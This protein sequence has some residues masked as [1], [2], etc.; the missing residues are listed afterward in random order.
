MTPEFNSLLQLDDVP[1]KYD[2]ASKKTYEAII[3]FH[4]AWR[5]RDIDKIVSTY[6]ADVEYNDFFQ[7][8][9]IP[10]DELREY[11]QA[12]MPAS[13]DEIQFYIDRLR[14][15][16]DTAFLQYKI[17]LRGANGL[18]SFSACEAITV[19]EGLIVKV[20]DYTTLTGLQREL[21]STPDSRT[22]I[23]RLGLSARQLGVLSRDLEQY[24]IQ[25]SPFLNHDLDLPQVAEATGYTRNQ[26]SFYLNKI[27]GCNFHQ[28]LN[29]ARLDHFIELLRD[30]PTNSRI[31]VLIY[32]AG[33]GSMSTCYRFFRERTGLSPKAWLKLYA[34]GKIQ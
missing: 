26:I 7:G 4:R 9:V 16:G 31:D 30:S 33:F 28:Y 10:A 18:T 8:R 32:E 34:K 11:L 12:G 15:D 1:C 24:F 27:L 3:K 14:V 20:N 5:A 21:D 22:G 25:A 6:S 23:E 17:S 2:G 13:G 19:K 29:R